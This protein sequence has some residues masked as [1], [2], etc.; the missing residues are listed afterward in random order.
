M[1]ESHVFKH[2]WMLQCR[3]QESLARAVQRELG[4]ARKLK[5]LDLGSL[6]PEYEALFQDKAEKIVRLDIIKRPGLDVVGFG[7]RLPFKDWSFDAVICTQ[8][9]EHV[10]Q[11]FECVGEIRRVLRKGGIVFLTTH[12]NWMVHNEPEDNW[13]FTPD[14][15]KRLFRDFEWMRIENHGGTLMALMLFFNLYF[16][17]LLRP[18]FLPERLWLWLRAPLY[19]LP[20]LLGALLD[21][22][23]RNSFTANYLVTARK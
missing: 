23:E 22:P 13:R 16:K 1:K 6:E 18:R 11:P 3:L 9:L 17:S 12:G 2:A 20:N 4:P 15:F 10:K 19:V 14:G 7:E 8:V 5:V 21:D